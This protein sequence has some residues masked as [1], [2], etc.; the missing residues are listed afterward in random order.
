MALL[1]VMLALGLSACQSGHANPTKAEKGPTSF[2]F[3]VIADGP[4]GAL[5]WAELQQGINQAAHSTKVI[6]T[7]RTA[8]PFT[9]DGMSQL[10]D[11]AIESRSD[12][13]AVAI[14]DCTG[15]G[16]AVRRAVLV[17]LPV[18]AFDSESTCTSTLGLF[19]AV[20][21]GGYQTGLVSGQKL[22][23]SGARHVLC[24]GEAAGNPE[25]DN[26][27][28]GISDALTQAKGKAEVLVIDP[29]NPASAQLIEKKLAQDASIDSIMALSPDAATLALTAIQS[30]K[31]AGHIKLATFDL[32]NA[33]LQ[34]V[35][36]GTILFAVDQRSYAQGYLSIDLLSHDKL[37]LANAVPAL[38]TA[39]P[40]FVDIQ[41]V[42]SVE[43]NPTW[44]T[45]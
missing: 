15:L 35:Q 34:A 4:P 2:H 39:Q 24:L 12:G 21:Q 3:V 23:S 45:P 36:R 13:L 14:P 43:G 37:H 32:S 19:N 30:T 6:V 25:F 27:C 28:R 5:F 41:N 11:Q 10:I 29:Q 18:V 44:L 38:A 16:P 8:D 7:Y 31:G 9:L 33:V 22:V 20:G 17:G 40:F 26:R 1:L 42:L